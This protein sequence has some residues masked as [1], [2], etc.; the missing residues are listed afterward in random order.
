[1]IET[2][3]DENQASEE[4]TGFYM[5]RFGVQGNVV[6]IQAGNIAL[7]RGDEIICRTHR[8]IELGEVLAPTQVGVAEINPPGKYIRRVRPE[9]QLLWKQLV[10]LSVDASRDCQAFLSDKGLPDFLIEVEPLI[11]GRTLYFHF[12]GEPSPETES[13]VQELSEI[14]QKKVAASKFAKLLEHGCG[15]GCG[16][17]D[18]SG[19]GTSGGCAVCAVTGGCG[20]KKGK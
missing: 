2:T 7:E 18:K 3:V 10:S 15:P 12:I 6:S 11:D 19:C 1:M 14:Y 4:L 8:G 9:D 16:T 13:Y 17:K 5:A 20:S